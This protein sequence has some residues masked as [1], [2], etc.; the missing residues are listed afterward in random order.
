MRV[1]HDTGFGGNVEAAQGDSLVCHACDCWLGWVKAHS[2]LADLLKVFQLTDVFA[3][4]RYFTA[5]NF[6][7]FGYESKDRITEGLLKNFSKNIRIIVVRRFDVSNIIFKSKSE[8][9]EVA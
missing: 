5:K 4:Y 3:S 6:I 9:I 8:N 2:F 7:N 1:Y